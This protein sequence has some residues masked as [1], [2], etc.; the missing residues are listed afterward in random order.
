[1]QSVAR[2]HY[3]NGEDPVGSKAMSKWIVTTRDVGSVYK[4][5]KDR[6]K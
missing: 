1:M 3:G 5:N 4:N 2:R 6:K